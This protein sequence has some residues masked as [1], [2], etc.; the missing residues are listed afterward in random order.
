[1]AIGKD[2][3]GATLSEND[4]S[5]ERYFK[6]DCKAP[7]GSVDFAFGDKRI[8]ISYA[9]F[10]LD[11]G[12]GQG[13][14]RLKIMTQEMARPT[15]TEAFFHAAYLVFDVDNKALWLDQAD[16]CGTDIKAIGKGTDAVPVVKG[17]CRNTPNKS[18]KGG[19]KGAGDRTASI[20]RSMLVAVGLVGTV[21]AIL[22]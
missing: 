17:C 3:P 4:D 11:A 13:T 22:L 12:D 2:Y 9:D 21:V 5:D 8:S 6:A 20:S 18:S 10:L 15:L 7:E 19:A 1:M 14:C 16:D